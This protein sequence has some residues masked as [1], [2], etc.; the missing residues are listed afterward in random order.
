MRTAVI[1]VALLALAAPL[2]SPATAQGGMDPTKSAKGDGTLPS[3]WHLSLDAN[4]R[5]KMTEKDV[6]FVTMGNGY[7]ATTGPA[8]IYWSDNNTANSKYTVSASFRQTKSTGMDEAYGLIFGGHDLAD[9][10]KQ[11]YI[12]FVVRGKDDFYVAHRSGLAVHKIIDWRTNPAVVPHDATGQATNVLSVAVGTD[13]LR[14][15]VNGKPVAAVARSGMLANTDGT[16]G[17]RV[18]HNPDLHIGDLK[19][20]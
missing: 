4:R 2:V 8:G 16:Y 20:Q 17:I 18:N 1:G 13:S 15:S 5:D 6:K 9:A 19:K 11:N 3:G 14:F 10:A 7:H 12:Y